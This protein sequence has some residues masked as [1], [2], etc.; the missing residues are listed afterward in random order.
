M[1]ILTAA[2]FSF[3]LLS[4]EIQG[5]DF[6]GS[7][8][9]SLRG[10]I[11]EQI[12]TF[13]QEK[14][15]VHCDKPV[16]LAGEKIWFRAYVTDAVLHIPSANQYVIVE[17]I[18]PLD[19]VVNRIKIRPDSGAFHGHIILDQALPEGDYTLRAY[20]ENMLNPGADYYF[21]KQIRVEGP[22][23]ASVNTLVTLKQE[24]EDK[25]TAEVYFKDIKS[26]QKIL[27]QNLRMRV[28]RQTADEIKTDVDSVAR[29][30][31]RIPAG[32]DRKV[33]YIETS[34]SREYIT[35]PVPDDDYD[36]SFYP[37]GGYIPAGTECCVA[38]K[39]LNSTGIP[40]AVTMKVIDDTGRETAVSRTI[41]D[42]MGQFLITARQ[43]S[44]YYA[45]CTNSR[46]IER[47]F[48][49]PPAQGGI[50][51]LSTGQ[52]GDTLLVS[53]LKSADIE[54][55]QELLLLLHTRGII[56]YAKPWNHNFNAVSFDTR[57]FPSGV[58]QIILFDSAMNPL[59]ER[60]V[61]CNGN[62][63]ASTVIVPDAQYYAKRSPV[64]ATLHITGPDGKP[65]AGSLSVSVTDDSDLLPD[66]SVTILTTLMLTSELR[67]YIDNPGF[68]F[69]KNN[70]LASVGLDLLMMTNGWRRYD[71]PAVMAGKYH[72]M[73]YPPK[74]GMEITGSVRSLILGKP[75]KET[76]V[77]AFSWGTGYIEMTRTDSLGRFLFSGIEFPDSTEFIIQA[78][79]K[80]GRPTVDLI[81]D[82]EKFPTAES[83]PGTPITFS[84]ETADN[85]RLSNY[86]TR[87][88]TR[89]SMENGMRTVYIEEV[90]ITAKAPEKEKYS[91]SFYMP[92]VNQESLSMLDYEKIEELHPTTMTDVINQI[93]FTRVEGGKVIIERM[94]F[95][96][97]GQ[98]NAVLVLDDMILNDY[99][100]DD[101]DPYSVER[102]AVLKGAQTTLLGGAGAGGAIVITTK[103]GMTPYKELPK[104][105]IK[106]I[107][108]LGYREPEEFYS[109][110]YET[111]DSREIGPPDLRT[112]IYWNPDV[113]VSLDGEA[114][115][116]F[117]T[118]DNPS[119]YTLL[120]EG[121]T[122]DG[123]IISCRSRISRR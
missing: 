11:I 106:K 3:L 71:L 22:L 60:L 99:H 81:L 61:F 123:L 19:S 9:D 37:E 95:S 114:L 117:Y 15:H 33:L 66:S 80:A 46:G 34:K 32:S 45:I 58:L 57:S 94:R 101:I 92:T 77:N 108:P 54:E 121:L 84:T 83:I 104:F 24:K 2:V 47:R 76:E 88:D 25:F 113:K 29:F 119:D 85:P 74:T 98:L 50:Y 63:Q 103:K 111:P 44:T 78:L 116:D 1:R 38:F 21:M 41:H 20:T 39:A 107:M 64:K 102:V 68:Y 70:P 28:N 118:A 16:Y 72:T 55:K 82:N 79:N 122:D 51:T 5:Q 97:N 26:G 30:S 75:V 17:L 93:P 40:E 48:Q 14:I 89:Y 112:T 42:G 6:R 87:A 7:P 110:R 105:N 62:D 49:L 23:S 91:Y 73:K 36:V 120:I 86:L 67:G 10:R 4:F 100:I 31:F 52:S 12:L 27:S 18:N 13:P 115:F 69:R 109:P 53:V 96:L 35:L 90:V 59:S 56:H 43:N 8:E 65:R